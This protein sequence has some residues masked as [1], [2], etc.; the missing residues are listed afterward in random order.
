MKSYLF[1]KHL[2]YLDYSGSTW[3]V[4]CLSS[5]ISQDQSFLFFWK[6]KKK[7]LHAILE[8]LY[9]DYIYS[10]ILDLFLF[11]LD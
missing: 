11:Y 7:I 1:I 10:F 8:N 3:E 4:I 5:F 9:R 6:R 2:A